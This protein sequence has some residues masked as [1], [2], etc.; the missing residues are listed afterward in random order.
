[1]N[2]SVSEQIYQACPRLHLGI[3]SCDVVN[4]S[5]DEALWEE[6]AAEEESLRLSMRMEEIAGESQY[7]KPSRPTRS[8]GKRSNRY[9]PSARS[10]VQE[11]SERDIRFTK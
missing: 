7:M 9:R 11:D 6:I 3:I 4:T 1:M 8:W 10:L 5:S 2:I